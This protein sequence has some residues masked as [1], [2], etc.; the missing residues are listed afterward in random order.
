MRKNKNKKGELLIVD[1]WAIIVFVIIILIMLIL[2]YLNKGNVSERKIVEAFENKDSALFLN[3]FLRAPY[4][5]NGIDKEKTIS[6]IIAQD[7]KSNEYSDTSYAIKEFFKGDYTYKKSEDESTKNTI[8]YSVFGYLELS[9]VGEINICIYN[10]NQQV[11]SFKYDL[12]TRELDED[13]G[14]CDEKDY[15]TEIPTVDG[16]IHVSINIEKRGLFTAIPWLE[17]I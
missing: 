1:F 15:K 10:N 14:S 17:W 7:Y 16:T 11:K 2:F 8:K 13:D 6:Y 4:I 9:L 5:E 3:A 12:E